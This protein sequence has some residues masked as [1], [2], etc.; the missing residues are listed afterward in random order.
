MDRLEDILLRLA[1]QYA[2]H[3]LRT[4]NPLDPQRV[5]K[6][7][8]YLASYNILVIMG[9]FPQTLRG[10]DED[11]ARPIQTWVDGYAQFYLLL[12]RALFPSFVGIAAQYA[13]NRWPVAITIRG[14]C[15]PVIEAMAGFVTPYVAMRQT[16]AVVS[17]IELIGL[18]EVILE[19]L[20]ATTLP[21]E[22]YKRLLGEGAGL[23]K[24]LL[25]SPIRQHQITNFDRRVF[26]DSE[27][28]IP[29]PP[30]PAKL[31][32]EDSALLFASDT[33]ETR[34]D[35]TSLKPEQAAFNPPT[36]TQ[37]LPPT[38]TIQ[39]GD[40]AKPPE[41]SARLPFFPPRRGGGRRRPPVPPLPGMEDEE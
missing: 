15:A 19:V 12:T 10:V 8:R 21:R 30:E 28:F 40:D 26:T 39:P 16:E 11:T 34:P 5:A 9:D 33:Q 18:M 29:I 13:D 20:E 41:G 31:P 38:E 36:D 32:E 3:I 23:L 22:A 6:L 27:R 17:E 14:E 1:Q 2:P 35:V 7:A 25:S 37:T 24:K 4:W